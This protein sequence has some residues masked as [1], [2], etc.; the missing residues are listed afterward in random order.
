MNPV[1]TSPL[2]DDITTA[3]SGLVEFTIETLRDYIVYSLAGQS[4]G[5]A[6]V[7]GQY[8]PAGQRVQVPLAS[9]A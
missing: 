3:P 9:V 4:K 7:T 2:A 5:S 6:V 1:P 8:F